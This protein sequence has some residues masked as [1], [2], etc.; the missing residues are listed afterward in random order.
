MKSL[1]RFESP[2]LV[3][4]ALSAL[5]GCGEA[6]SSPNTNE[7]GGGGSGGGA[8][9]GTATG[10]QSG[11]SSNPSGGNSASGSAGTGG[12]SSAGN[13][14][15]AGSA[16]AAGSAPELG[17]VVTPSEL[18]FGAVQQTV[19]EPQLVRLE[20]QSS[21]T[22]QLTTLTLDPQG[23]SSLEV[24]LPPAGGLGLAAG[25]SLELEA[26]F[27][28]TAIGLFESSLVIEA[29]GPSAKSTVALYGLG[30]KGLEGENEPY[31]KIVLT[32]LGYDVDVGGAALLS[33]TTPLVGSEVAAPRFKVA[34]AGP[35]AITPVARYSPQEPIPY[36]YYSPAGEFEVGIISDDQYQAL[37]PATDAGTEPSFMDPG[38]EFGV[39][40]TSKTH[41]TYTEDAKN[42]ANA[43]KHAARTYPLRDR[44]GVA[45]EHAYL[46]CFEEA[47]NGD[48]QDYVFTLRNVVPVAP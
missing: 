39:F 31:L 37:N 4:L 42:A 22:L 17:L 11:S 29:T 35:I 38:G 7:A 23:A 12:T 6:S 33:T 8:Q 48:Y 46:V 5:S 21:A 43:V 19:S 3:L 27:H 16:G 24:D 32:T 9:A 15:S 20:N 10:G 14:G 40:T 25:E 41:K 28:P 45:I 2:I 44:A 34:G 1:P 47:A 13:A 26:R 30:T 36:G 18:V